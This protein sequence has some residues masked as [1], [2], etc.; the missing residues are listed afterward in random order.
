RTCVTE[1]RA[2]LAL[3]GLNDLARLQM[4]TLLGMC[5]GQLPDDADARGAREAFERALEINAARQPYDPVSAFQYVQFL[6]RHG[7]TDAAERVVD[8]ILQRAPRFAPA[9]LE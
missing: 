4:Y 1:E 8:Q 5:H 9:R 3:P 7:D 6:S 2:A